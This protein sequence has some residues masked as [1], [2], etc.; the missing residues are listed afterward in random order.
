[1]IKILFY[2]RIENIK[3]KEM[4]RINIERVNIIINRFK[5]KKKKI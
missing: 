5:G 1:M 3:Q 4:I 2:K